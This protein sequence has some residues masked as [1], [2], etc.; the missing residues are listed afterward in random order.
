[1]SIAEG[2]VAP[3]VEIRAQQSGERRSTVF[4]SDGPVVLTVEIADA[5]PGDVH[6]V[7]WSATDARLIPAEGFNDSTFTFD[8]ALATDGVYA[9]SV[10]VVDAAGASASERLYLRFDATAPTLSASLDS[11]GDGVDDSAEGFADADGNGVPAWLDPFDEARWIPAATNQR[12]LLQTESGLTLRPGAAAISNGGALLDFTDLTQYGSAGQPAAN[13]EDSSHNYP[14]GLYDFE[15]HGL[16]EPGGTAR[17][18]IALPVPIPA[19]ALYRKFS[20][21]TGWTDFVTDANNAIRSAPGV[22]GA[23][24]AP[25]SADYADGLTAGHFCVELTI[26][27]GGPNDADG[28]SDG[29]IA[30][31]AALRCAHQD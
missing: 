29:K 31:P 3:R 23:C 8:P 12:G 25:G 30:D 9:V 5:N 18:V 19:N 4:G 16:P 20:S 26:E 21:N 22:A 27:D 6:S 13:T 14:A 15:V 17:V 24:P 2:N 11:D 7:D 28:M 10:A 1:M